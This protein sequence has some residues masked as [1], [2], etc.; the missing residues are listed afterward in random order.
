MPKKKI[1]IAPPPVLVTEMLPPVILPPFPQ[2][3][4]V[5]PKQ[6]IVKEDDYKPENKKVMI[7][8]MA[9][10]VDEVP[11]GSNELIL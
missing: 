2:L 1:S 11:A 7:V 8:P 5:L 3:Q 4:T 10:P 9:V 6:K